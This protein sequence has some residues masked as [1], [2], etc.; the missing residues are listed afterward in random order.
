MKLQNYAMGEW[1]E[2]NGRVVDLVNAVTG[3]KIAEASSGGLDF[4]GMIEYAKRVGG[5]TLRA[6]TFHQR[7]AMLKAHGR[8]DFALEL[9]IPDTLQFVGDRDDLTEVLGNLMDNAV[10]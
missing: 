9:A 6:M 8:K 2:G 10:K 4:K 3:E 1:V 5:P 7:A